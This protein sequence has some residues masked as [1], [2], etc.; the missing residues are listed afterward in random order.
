[1]IY[2]QALEKLAYM[3]DLNQVFAD[4]LG[5]AT[6]AANTALLNQASEGLATAT[7]YEAFIADI[8]ARFVLAEP[9][10]WTDEDAGDYDNTGVVVIE[11]EAPNVE[12][13]EDAGWIAPYTAPDLSDWSAHRKPSLGIIDLMHVEA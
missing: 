13:A 7:D 12:E 1:M 6:V 9:T 3:A 2:E 8:E 10:T 4:T 11:D 5:A